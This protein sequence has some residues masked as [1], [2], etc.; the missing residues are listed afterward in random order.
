VRP[1]CR[2]VTWRGKPG[3][4]EAKE[5]GGT[6]QGGWWGVSEVKVGCLEEDVPVG[7][8][9]HL[10][11]EGIA[12]KRWS[13]EQ[14]R[15]IL[16]SRVD[17][18]SLLATTLAGLNRPPGVL[19]SG[20]AIGFY[21]DRGDTILTEDAAPGT[22]FFPEVC[23]EWEDATA[24]AVAAGIRTA[25]IRSGIVL[26]AAGGA[27]ERLLAPFGPSWISPYR[28]GLGGWVGNGRQWWSWIALEDEIRAIL[29]VLEGGLSGPV[30]LTAPD[31]VT[32]KTFMRAVGKALRRPVMLPIPE[33]V[34]KT[35]L[36]SE[37]AEATLFDSQR[38]MP[39]E[40]LEDGFE[41]HHTDV[42]ATLQKA[43]GS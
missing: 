41:F 35:V 12:E 8:V 14:K 40:L 43:I 16:D 39:A 29:H 28:W 9:V 1:F 23:R 25:T 31:P 27:L 34:F 7:A 13:A 19:L 26:S 36:G 11:G 21:G 17:G 42:T 33:F 20:S 15:R 38:V 37:L 2:P 22:G 6:W 18:T 5:W 3:Q 24:P 30:N 32:N 4:N 10:A